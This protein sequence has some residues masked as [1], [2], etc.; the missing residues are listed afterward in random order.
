MSKIQSLITLVH[1]LTHAEK[2]AFRIR[3]GRNKQQP[4]YLLLYDIID[5]HP[6]LSKTEIQTMF[7]ETSP[8]A[9]FETTSKYLFELL[10]ESMLN[11]RKEQDSFIFLYKKIIHARMLYEK[12]LISESLNILEEV[13]RLAEKYENHNALLLALRLELDYLLAAGFPTMDEKT[14]LKKQFKLTD[15]LKYIRK[16]N[17]QSSLYEILKHRILNKGQIRTQKQK[18][19]LNDLVF[20]EISLVSSLNVDNFEINKLHQLFQSNYLISVGDYQSALNSYYELNNLFEENK[21]LWNKPPIYYL[22]TLEGILESLRSIRN[23][24]GMSYFIV[25]LKNIVCESVTFKLNV[26]CTTYLYELFPLLDH[27]EFEK[28]S[29]LMITYRDSLYEKF[30]SLPRSR[31]AELSLYTSLVYFVNGEYQKAHKFLNQIILHEKNYF[32]LPL[33]RTIRLVNLMI[34]YKMNDIDLIKY[35]IRTMMRDIGG[36]ER[37]YR[38]ERFLFRFLSNPLPSPS[39]KRIQVWNKTKKELDDIKQDLFERKILQIF[40][41][42]AWIES[43]LTKTPLSEVLQQKSALV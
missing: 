25:Q 37:N 33:F 4:D 10:L 28:C 18:D 32:S 15:A 41:F 27:G 40:D 16:I 29:K 35:E 13:I 39:F 36:F 30:N 1:S 34:L 2:K 22:H 26:V 19:D 21:H 38:I 3:S 8:R 42:T 7:A 5:K 6:A 14:L 17:E 20:S 24:E 11:L 23:Y 9:T 31:Q 43:Q 12:S